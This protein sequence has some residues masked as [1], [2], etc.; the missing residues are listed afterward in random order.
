ME[1]SMARLG[2]RIDMQRWN[3]HKSSL[4]NLGL[5]RVVEKGGLVLSRDLN[6]VS[7]WELYQALPWALP[8]G[9]EQA[10]EGWQTVLNRTLAD[11]YSSGEESLKFDVE[12]LFRGEQA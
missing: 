7:L 5:I 1:K 2:H 3:E 10:D 8:G 4:L 6:E 11:L 12:R 9:F